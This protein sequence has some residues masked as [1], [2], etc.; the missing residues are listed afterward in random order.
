MSDEEVIQIYREMEEKFEA[1]PSYVHEPMQFAYL[2]KLYRYYKA[3]SKE[4]KCL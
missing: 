4:V 1:L 2:V 3:R